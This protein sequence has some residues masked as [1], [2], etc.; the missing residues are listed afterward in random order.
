MT[1]QTHSKHA[2]GGL[3]L[4]YDNDESARMVAQCYRTR[5]TLVNPII[6]WEDDDVWGFIKANGIHYCSLYDEGWSR[7]GCIGCPMAGKGRY[8]QFGRYPTYKKMYIHTFDRMIKSRNER[9]KPL[10]HRMTAEG[11][12]HWWIEDGVI[13]GQTDL[14]GSIDSSEDF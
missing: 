3:V 6:D 14:F 5:R 9:G 11:Y 8:K 2:G 7:I 10:K 4:N 13:E 1:E 12:Y